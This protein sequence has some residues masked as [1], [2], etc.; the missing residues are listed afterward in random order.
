MTP[1]QRGLSHLPLQ[2]SALDLAPQAMQ[3]RG[4]HL[5]VAEDSMLWWVENKGHWCH[6]LWVDTS[7]CLWDFIRLGEASDEE[8]LTFAEVYGVLGL[9][10]FL[11]E[12]KTE[13]WCREGD[14]QG[15][16]LGDSVDL[17]RRMA[18]YARAI[19]SIVAI[20]QANDPRDD[21]LWQELF[22]GEAWPTEENGPE[23][24]PESPAWVSDSTTRFRRGIREAVNVW[25]L[26]VP[27]FLKL[28]WGPDFF[29]DDEASKRSPSRSAT[30]HL[31]GPLL[32][33]A[34]SREKPNF[35]LADEYQFPKTQPTDNL[36]ASSWAPE[37][38][39]RATESRW[40]FRSIGD[41]TTFSEFVPRQSKLFQIIV[42]KLL[43]VLCSPVY[44]CDICGQPFEIAKRSPSAN[45]AKTC[46]RPECV[47]ARGRERAKDS[48]QRRVGAKNKAS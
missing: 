4:L 34:K 35:H 29:Q 30:A 24:T 22:P 26:S 14:S 6:H 28:Y 36:I 47:K 16:V 32:L 17:Y 7:E 43:S 31:W 42:V 48:Y 10:P 23:A 45:R 21:K 39:I 15:D 40:Q 44:R 2:V 41:R 9:W 5:E 33:Q 18:R 1:N 11:N 38:Y 3:A 27:F 19:L 37:L 46:G 12:A 13:D 25:A 20:H 8:I